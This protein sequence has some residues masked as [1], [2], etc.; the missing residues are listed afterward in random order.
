[1]GG[2]ATGK[3]AGFAVRTATKIATLGHMGNKKDDEKAGQ[4]KS[5]KRARAVRPLPLQRC[6][7]LRIVG[8]SEP[9]THVPKMRAHGYADTCC[10]LELW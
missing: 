1:M 10:V 4:T 7:A 5:Q 9:V 8:T 3:V 2:K 6:W